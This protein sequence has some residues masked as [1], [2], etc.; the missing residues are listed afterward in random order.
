MILFRGM[1]TILESTKE[2]ETLRDSCVGPLFSIGN[3]RRSA[4]DARP[5][6][7]IKCLQSLLL[8][9]VDTVRDQDMVRVYTLAVEELAKSYTAVLGTSE[10]PGGCEVSN[11]LVWLYVV[12]D[13]YL[14]LFDKRSPEA[15]VIFA[16]FCV[17]FKSVEWAWWIDGWRF[18]LISM[19]YHALDQEHKAWLQWP[20]E[21]IGWIPG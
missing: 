3:R 8:L 20:M 17:L 6:R 21:Q 18:Y 10:L 14:E 5:V 11:V 19:I 4:R 9:I 15:L 1:R 16:Y 2:R 12:S 13:E 7:E